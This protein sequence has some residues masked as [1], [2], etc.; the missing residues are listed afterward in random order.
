M[1]KV[2]LQIEYTRAGFP[3]DSYGFSTENR[4]E[5][6]PLGIS[7]ILNN[8][9]IAY[10]GDLKLE[11]ELCFPPQE[12]PC[13][14]FNPSELQHMEDVQ[15]V[16]QAVFTFG[17]FAGLAAIVIAVILWRFISIEALRLAMMQGSFLTLGLIFTII[18]L[19]L[20]AWDTFFGGF[21]SIFFEEGT[22]QFF[23]S[24]TLIRLY[25]QQFWFDASLVVGG[26][27]TLGAILILLIS[28]RL[29]FAK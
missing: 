29:G 8:E 2:F 25:P 22:W 23:Y 5:Y 15:A 18:L 16:A 1:T 11:G 13:S 28:L 24:D 4:L 21:H 26:L 19:A 20:T 17:I 7:Y 27:T 9:P 14:A 3:E 6:G 10:L 12:N